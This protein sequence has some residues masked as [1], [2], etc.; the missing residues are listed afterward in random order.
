MRRLLTVTSALLLLLAACG[1]GTDD[2]AS[3]G[4][5]D[6]AAATPTETA[7]TAAPPADDDGGAGETS[8]EA[9]DP[10]DGAVDGEEGSQGEGPSTATVTLGG[11]TYDFS[12]E[13]A[14]VAQCLTD[15]FG[16]FSVQLPLIDDSGAVG[17]GS[18]QIAALRE[19]TDPATV[20]L[21]NSVRLD[22]G[23]EIWVADEASEVLTNTEGFEPGTS[24][25]DTVEVEG[26]TVRGT[27]TFLRQNSLFG[28]GDVETVSGTF[29]ATC[30]EERTT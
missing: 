2:T 10:G 29:E 28:E 24:Q 12:T 3:D 21:G 9:E 26:R 15:L 16:V 11:D 18:V 7:E 6:Q 30:G 13:G 27:A 8:A 20:G 19:G 17:D 25:V 1:G 22:L 14:T 4:V 23:D 5:D